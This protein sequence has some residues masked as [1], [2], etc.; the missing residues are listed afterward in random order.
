MGDC[1][2][3]D[4]D[5][6]V[7]D[8][9]P[10]SIPTG[11]TTTITGSGSLKKDVTGGSYTMDMTGVL[12]AV[13]VKNCTGDA[14]QANTCDIEAPL[15]GKVG[16]L[17]YQP[18]TFP[19]KAGAISGVPKVAVTLKA[20]L[21][22]SVEATTTTL[23]V[24]GS[25]GDNVICVRIM[26]KAASEMKLLPAPQVHPASS[27]LPGLAAP[28]VNSGSLAVT[29]KDCGDADTDAVVKD[30]VP[31][32]IQAGATTTITGSGSLKR[33]VTGGSYTMDMTGVL[34]AVLVKNCKGDAGQANTCDIEAPLFGKVGSLSYQ[35]ATFPIKAGDISG[36]PKV[37]VT[38]KAGLPSSVESTTTTLRVT[39]ADGDKV[40]CVKIMTKAASSMKLLP[41]T[42]IPPA[43]SSLPGLAV[44]S[45]NSGSLAVTF[46]DCG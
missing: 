9:I 44:P 10:K 13:L 42:E 34:G 8:V 23:K 15:F 38:L 45:V 19:I 37:G 22:S 3:A 25:D 31:K 18:A 39:G 1:G 40:I 7:K 26:T 16:S 17:S 32:F 14:G 46:K 36:V 2:D 4:T 35:P 41:A 12:G 21:P 28:F 20:G 33:D 24:T 30:V 11:A 27:S 5:A 29:F 43:S 6:V